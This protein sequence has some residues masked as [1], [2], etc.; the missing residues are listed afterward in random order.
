[1]I[2]TVLALTAVRADAAMPVSPLAD[3]YQSYNDCIAVASPVGIDQAKLASLGWVRA[4]SQ[5]SDGKPIAGAP[6]IYG[7]ADRKPLI[8]LSDPSGEGLCIVMARLSNRAAFGE[9]LKAWHGALPAAD[10]NGAIS[11][12]DEGHIVQIRQTGTDR[13]PGLSMAVMT[14]ETK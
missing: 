9:F 8:I 13:E 4:T 2:A 5:A 3:I 10:G 14:P 11:F 1:M 12:R 7:K 6:L